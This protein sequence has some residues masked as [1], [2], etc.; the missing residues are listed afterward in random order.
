MNDQTEDKLRALRDANE[1]WLMAQPGVI[2]TGIG[3]DESGRLVIRVYVQG[4][5]ESTRQAIRARLA[6]A[7]VDFQQGDIT[8][9]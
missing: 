8:A 1:S 6:G 2:G 7:T 5:S 4:I 9:Y 3:I